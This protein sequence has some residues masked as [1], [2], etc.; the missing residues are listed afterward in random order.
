[1][2]IEKKQIQEMPCDDTGR[3]FCCE[4]SEIGLPP[5][6]WPA[7]LR[8]DQDVGNGR[9][10]ICYGWATDETMFYVQPNQPGEVDGIELHILND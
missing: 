7:R 9:D 5:G 8:V 10:L 2:I 6:S 3:V 1:M 4:A